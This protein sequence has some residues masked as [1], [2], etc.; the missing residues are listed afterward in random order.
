MNKA[1]MLLG[2]SSERRN[3][4][5]KDVAMLNA[6]A[7]TVVKFPKRKTKKRKDGVNSN[8][9]GSVREIG[10]KAYV[11]LIYLNERVRESTGLLWNDKNAKNAREQLDKINVAVKSGSFRFADVFPDSKRRNYFAE[12]EREVYGR[13]LQPNDIN[14]GDYVLTW[15]ERLKD[16]GRVTGMTLFIYKHY[17]DQY[18]VPFFKDSNFSNLNKVLFERFIS[19]ART[20]KLKGKQIGNTTVNKL[21]IPL[22]MIC[23][24]VSIE[25]GWGAS[26]NPFFGFNRLKQDDAYEKINP[27]SVDE[28]KKIIQQLDKHWKPYFRFA[29]SIGLRHGEQIGIKPE[30]INWKKKLL[31]IRRAITHDVDGKII[32]GRT[33]NKYSRRT[34]KLSE[35]MLKILTAQKAIHEK[36]GSEYFFC[37][38]EGKLV[39]LDNLRNRAWKKALEDAELVY[40]DLKQ[41]RHSFA[42]TALSNGVSPL[43]IARVMGHRNTEMIIRVYSKYI[44]ANDADHS[45]MDVFDDIFNGTKKN[46]G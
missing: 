11:D 8:R 38:P 33:K 28:Q 4:D 5:G 15:Y 40:R 41:T 25:Y 23:K 18:L 1:L 26:Y 34:I 3:G 14:V 46:Q 7:V 27:C 45:E 24:D 39:Q 13:E 30:D 43:L 17:I 2:K 10:G 44:E 6:S 16:S 42:T 29:F 19:W 31:H 12:K 21:F 32:E 35:R 22:R 36:L 37:S 20:R 9:E